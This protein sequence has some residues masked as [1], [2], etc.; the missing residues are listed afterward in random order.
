MGDLSATGTSLVL[1]WGLC[2]CLSGAFALTG[3]W[4][5]TD[6]TWVTPD[7]WE[8]DDGVRHV[9]GYVLDSNLRTGWQRAAQEDSWSLTFDLQT[10]ITLSRVRMRYYHARN[11]TISMSTGQRPQFETVKHFPAA[12]LLPACSGVER[13]VCTDGDCDVHEVICDGIVDCD[14]GSDETDCDKEMCPDGAVINKAQVCDSRDDC[15]DGTDELNCSAATCENG[16]LFHPATRCNGRDDCGD[17][18]DENNCDCYYLNDKGTSY[19]GRA[20]RDGSCQFWTS[21]YPHTHNHTP[22]AYP[23]AGLEQ[24]YCRNPDGKDRPW[25][26]TNN[27]LI[28]WMYCEDVFACDAVP[29]RCFYA[30]DSGRSYAGH[31]NRAGDRVCQRWDSQSPHSHPHTP[32]AHPDAGL[33]ENFCRNPGNKERPW[34]YTMD[35]TLRWS[36]C[37]V[38]ECADP[39]SQDFIGQECKG[40]YICEKGLCYCDDDCSFFGDC[41]EVVDLAEPPPDYYHL[42]WKCVPG[43]TDWQSYWLVADCPDEW[44]DD[45][46]RGQCLQQVDTFSPS[47]TVYRIP[48]VEHGSYIP[49]RNI[50][51]ALCNN[52][53]VAE[54][55]FW[56]SPQCSGHLESSA[57]AQQDYSNLLSSLGVADEEVEDC[58]GTN[59]LEFELS[60]KRSCLSPEID[61]SNAHCDITA[62]RSYSY[63][64]F[65]RHKAY[66]NLHCALCEGLSLAAT[67]HLRCGI[68]GGGGRDLCLKTAICPDEF[69]LT[70]L[71]NFGADESGE[72]SPNQCPSDTVYDPFV[73]TCRDFSSASSSH[74]SSNK[75]IPLQ[76]CSEPA[77]TFTADEFS[78]LPNGSVHLLG[79]N[80][81]CPA[82][83]VAILNTTA[84]ICGECIL[85]HFSNN[86]QTTDNRDPA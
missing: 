16:A 14:D 79:S 75:T 73:D 49:Y 76:N 85:Q 55:S 17:N 5:E 74:D 25:C 21:Q 13:T 39:T 27:P 3:G 48:V 45:V 77:L 40:K 22:Q 18:S 30:T 44:T 86:T 57:Q 35:L 83:Q 65:S 80:V 52:V 43:F 60:N 41:C 51:C 33:E 29:T 12:D 7:E 34:C 23:S 69:S 32:Q 38:M 2:H 53:T 28:R 81:S 78:V 8:D 61:P 50:F 56:V 47:D 15:G 42:K 72:N 1:L 36:Y 84:S 54:A 19:R 31:V 70:R 58:L 10:P 37:N 67:T 46:T 63:P 64:V 82:E 59:K 11:V 62:C 26:Y 66:R 68:G 6:P 24:N 4:V 9:A 20:N 71:F